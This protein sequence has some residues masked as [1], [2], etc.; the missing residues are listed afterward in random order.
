M[1]PHI[2]L[3]HGSYPHRIKPHCLIRP[4]LTISDRCPD[5]FFIKPNFRLPRRNPCP[6]YISSSCRLHTT[7]TT[8]GTSILY[9]TFAILACRSLYHIHY[10][11]LFPS[12]YSSH[13]PSH[14]SPP[15]PSLLILSPL[16]PH[17]LFHHD[18]VRLHRH[19]S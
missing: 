3:S 16:N 19:I 6:H 5:F 9:T 18:Y 1:F 8:H 15:S 2:C 11:S 17:V 7:H 13:S 4:A 10:H 12:N 14:H